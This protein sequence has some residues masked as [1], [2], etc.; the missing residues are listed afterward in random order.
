MKKRDANTYK[1]YLA[2]LGFNQKISDTI[3]N[4]IPGYNMLFQKL[5]ENKSQIGKNTNTTSTKGYTITKNNSKEELIKHTMILVACL[6]AV[7]LSNDNTVL[8]GELK[9]FTKSSLQKKRDNTLPSFTGIIISKAKS[10]LAN[11]QPYGITQ[12]TIDL[13][14]ALQ[15]TYQKQVSKIRNLISQRKTTTQQT[16][17]LFTQTNNIL[18]QIDNLVNTVELLHPNFHT[19]YF[20]NRKTINYGNRTLSLRGYILD[21]NKNPITEA[22]IEIQSIR[23]YA[24]STQKGYF[25]FKNLP[26]GILNLTI[27]RTLYNKT[28]KA[29]GIVKGERKDIKI[30]LTKANLLEETA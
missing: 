11:L 9:P 20:I 7:A 8:L 21:E 30:T 19:E 3:K 10:N 26:P 15:T 24:R 14:E 18:K 1:M 22:K 16:Q 12:Q 17:Q 29:V 5:E 28:T 2:V 27:T 23:R 25:E 13:L 6:R 4:A